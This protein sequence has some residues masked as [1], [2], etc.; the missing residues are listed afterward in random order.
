VTKAKLGNGNYKT[1]T[2]D[3][4]ATDGVV[5]LVAADFSADIYN[6]ESSYG[7]NFYNGEA[8]DRFDSE[9]QHNGRLRKW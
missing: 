7:T 1:I 2:G 6:P 9:S 5:D 4:C 3:F 8:A